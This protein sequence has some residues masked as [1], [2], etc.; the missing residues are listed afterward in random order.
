MLEAAK[1]GWYSVSGWYIDSYSRTEE[2]FFT[3]SQSQGVTWAVHFWERT[4]IYQARYISEF[5]ARTCVRRS[6]IQKVD[7]GIAAVVNALKQLRL[8]GLIIVGG[9]EVVSHKHTQ[10]RSLVHWPG[11]CFLERAP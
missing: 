2:V 9:W 11:F 6:S 8:D 4:E 10:K 1:F 3:P 7:G 5:P